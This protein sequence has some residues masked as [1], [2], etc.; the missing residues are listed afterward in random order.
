MKGKCIMT[1][2]EFF[3]AIEKNEALTADIRRHAKMAIK[4]L[5]KANEGRKNKPSKKSKENEPI[6]LKIFEYLAE[7][8]YT[9]ASEI[10]EAVEISPNKASAL[11]RQ[12]VEEGKLE[13]TEI[14]V[15]GSGKVKAYRH[16]RAK[17]EDSTESADDSTESA[18]DIPKDE[19][20]M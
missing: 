1:N 13:R 7:A 6:K 5:D 8:D 2:R 17:I 19:I 20:D 3:E 18:D 15:K 14:K 12:L 10:A 9:P 4:K 11:C 16:V